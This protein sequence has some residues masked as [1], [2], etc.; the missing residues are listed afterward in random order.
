MFSV[1]SQTPGPSS[2][3]AFSKGSRV[4]TFNSGLIVS[5]IRLEEMRIIIP[6]RAEKIWFFE[7]D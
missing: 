5:K 7:S 3:D 4:K 6:Y 2:V 1:Q